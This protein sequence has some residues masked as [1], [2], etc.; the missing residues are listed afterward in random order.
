MGSTFFGGPMD[1]DGVVVQ[2][3]LWYDRIINNQAA[4]AEQEQRQEEGLN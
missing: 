1:S 4:Y 3:T 2:R